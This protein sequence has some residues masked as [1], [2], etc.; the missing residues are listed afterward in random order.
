MNKIYKVKKLG[1]AMYVIECPKCGNI[2]ASA[3]ERELL[4]E[5][6]TCNC[7]NSVECP[8]CHHWYAPNGHDICDNCL[9]DYKQKENY[10]Q[11]PD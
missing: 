3:S 1:Q 5:F 9:N 10:E 2:C 8:R 4:P 11:I 7:S 6:S